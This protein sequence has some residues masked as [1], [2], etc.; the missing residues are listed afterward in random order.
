[1]EFNRF[2]QPDE[3]WNVQNV[4]RLFNQCGCRVFCF[5]KAKRMSQQQK[6]DGMFR[7]GLS[8][9]MAIML[10]K[11]VKI[12]IS[13]CVIPC[14][15]H[16]GGRGWSWLFAGYLL[17]IRIRAAIE[18]LD[19]LY[20]YGKVGKIS[21]TELGKEQFEED[22]T[23][24]LPESERQH[25]LLLCEEKDVRRVNRY[26]HMYKDAGTIARNYTGQFFDF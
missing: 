5:R 14:V 25:Y 21:V 24:L 7:T 16:G 19:Q 10:S 12:I 6:S 11:Q 2:F 15:G 20:Q 4:R 26:M 23:P 9:I 22:D 18:L 3:V 8:Y 13:P 1:M 17:R